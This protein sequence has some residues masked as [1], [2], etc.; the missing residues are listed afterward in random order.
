MRRI[1]GSHTGEN[2]AE[3]MIPVLE[4]MG[5]VSRLGYF[6]GNNAGPNDT[7]WRAI[8]CIE[9]CLIDSYLRNSGLY[10]KLCQR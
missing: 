2:I 4:E 1:K 6:V 10:E 9:A 5:V 3:V 8:C 7:C